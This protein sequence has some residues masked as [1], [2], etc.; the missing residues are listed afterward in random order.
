MP[1]FQS[2]FTNSKYKAKIF[3]IVIVKIEIA[4]SRKKCYIGGI[5]YLS[6]EC[7]ARDGKIVCT[8]KRK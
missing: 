6:V 7:E 4:G 5:R 3:Q 2:A 8:W 1:T